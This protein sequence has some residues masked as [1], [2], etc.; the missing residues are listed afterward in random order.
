MKSK[1]VVFD[2]DKVMLLTN[3]DLNQIKGV[4]VENPDLSKVQGIP[5][6]FWKVSDHGEIYPMNQKEIKQKDKIIQNRLKSDAL[7]KEFWH[8]WRY[9]VFFSLGAFFA[10]GLIKFYK[11][12]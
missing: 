7:K 11:G 3:P 5:P 8:H 1:F 2:Q 4:I 10:V 9:M 12:I 6:H